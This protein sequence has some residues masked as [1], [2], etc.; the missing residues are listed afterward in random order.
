[1]ICAKSLVPLHTERVQPPRR[2]ADSD[3]ERRRA[4]IMLLT[5]PLLLSVSLAARRTPLVSQRAA[6]TMSTPDLTEGIKVF[7]AE[8]ATAGQS[9]DAAKVVGARAP[10][11]ICHVTAQP[12]P[13]LRAS[14]DPL[15]K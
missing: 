5:R 10:L 4:I 6:L 7:W 8:V 12:R 1:M 9:K 15:L 3:G 11:V 14:W 2:A 13:G